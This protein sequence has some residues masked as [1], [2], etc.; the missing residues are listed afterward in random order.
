M[1]KLVV[2][3]LGLIG[4]SLAL[5][6]KKRNGYKVYGI[7]ADATH[8]KKALSLGVIDAETNFSEIL[9]ASVVI[10]AVP[11]DIIPKVIKKVLDNVSKNTLVFDVGST[12]EGVCKAIKEHPKRA[13]FIAVHPIA[14]TEFS[15]PTAAI[16]N[17]FQN[18]KNII[19]DKELSSDSA[20]NMALKIC[21]QLEMETYFLDSKSHDVHL[22]Y[23]SH[24]SHITSFMLGLTV[25][26]IEKDEK[27][28]LNLA[29]TGF[30]STVRLA[31]SS[32][33]TWNPIFNKNKDNII[34]A[35]DKYINYMQKFR[36]ELADKNELETFEMM[37]KANK[38]K[39]VLK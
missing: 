16:P 17:L 31:K 36:N 5:D 38:I 12:K 23:V 13:N 26:D 11:V 4:G 15:G 3:G 28:I 22:A 29:S 2:I 10:V 6:L 14:G 25:L 1:E 24:L 34:T 21:M 9:D 27:Q 8:V 33:K 20:L 32:P 37:N 39:R 18:K 30:Q 19:C 35:L 7:D